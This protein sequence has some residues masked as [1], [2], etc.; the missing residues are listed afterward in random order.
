MFEEFPVFRLLIDLP[1]SSSQLKRGVISH[2]T[3][4]AYVS[5]TLHS[6]PNLLPLHSHTS[7]SNA[8]STTPPQTL[9][10]HDS[11]H[12]IHLPNYPMTNPGAPY[13]SL[14]RQLFV[15]S[16]DS[17]CSFSSSLSSVHPASGPHRSPSAAAVSN[18]S[19]QA[20][21]Q[22]KAIHSTAINNNHHL[23]SA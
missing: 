19:K 9:H 11:V 6:L 1:Q 20:A 17:S 18:N 7:T 8:A 14:R 22:Q 3:S 12:P 2:H 4:H 15:I 21:N 16:V 5:A 10:R 23:G 13:P